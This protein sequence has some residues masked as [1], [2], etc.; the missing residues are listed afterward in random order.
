MVFNKENKTVFILRVVGFILFIIHVS[1]YLITFLKDPG[2]PTKDLWIEN[3]KN[4]NSLIDFRICNTCKIVMKAENK[5]EHCE[6]CNIC[7]VGKK[8]F[9]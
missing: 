1:S 6:V 7:I 9:I 5:T 8:D 3:Y 2:L 4:Q